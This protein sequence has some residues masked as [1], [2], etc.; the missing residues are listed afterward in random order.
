ME[1]TAVQPRYSRPGAASQSLDP[2][3][4]HGSRKITL[5]MPAPMS[6]LRIP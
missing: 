5:S 1:S 3:L 6:P 2:V 4:G